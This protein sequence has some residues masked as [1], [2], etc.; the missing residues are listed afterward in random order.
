M[1]K[2]AAYMLTY[3]DSN[4]AKFNIERMIDLVDEIIVISGSVEAN[5]IKEEDTKI[6]ETL[7]QINNRKIKHV[8][9][10]VWKDKNEMADAA[11]S[12]L[13]KS[14]RFLFQLDSD[15]FWPQNTF[16]NA[17]KLLKDGYTTIFI[18]H[19]I[20]IKNSSFILTSNSSV[21]YYC[22]PRAFSLDNAKKLWHRSS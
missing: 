18:P 10:K 22:P 14:T 13:D 7:K 11:F 1:P 19:Y 8:N 9:Q 12:I 5:P 15:E 6:T 21:F 2:I 3:M 20:F 4:W 17:L 16:N